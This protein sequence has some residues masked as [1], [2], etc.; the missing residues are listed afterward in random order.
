MSASLPLV[1][2]I[3]GG[4]SSPPTAALG[5]SLGGGAG[6]SARGRRH[7]P[8]QAEPIVTAAALMARWARNEQTTFA[9]NVDFAAVNVSVGLDVLV[10]GPLENEVSA[11]AASR[12]SGRRL[13]EFAVFPLERFEL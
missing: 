7:V 5:S 10:A 4:G 8:R 13:G 1:A 6:D 3:R 9:A 2:Q 11:G 12:N